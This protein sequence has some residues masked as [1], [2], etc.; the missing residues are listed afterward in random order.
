MTATS[1]TRT[2][3]AP[4]RKELLKALAERGYSGPRSFTATALRRILDW[5]RTSAPVAEA[6]GIPSGALISMHPDLQPQAAH[7][8]R[9][10]QRKQAVLDALVDV[11][12]ILSNDG[13]AKAKVYLAEKIDALQTS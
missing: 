6:D 8:R 10:S 3:T 2:A 13:A 9:I 4:T 7:P 12:M 11:G 5:F 1:R